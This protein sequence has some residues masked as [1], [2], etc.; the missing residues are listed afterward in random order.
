MKR[1]LKPLPGL[2]LVLIRALLLWVL[3]PFGFIFYLLTLPWVLRRSS[4]LGQFLG[5]LD[6]NMCIAI[7][8]G[9]LRPFVPKPLPAWISSR[10]MKGVTHRI[11][12]PIDLW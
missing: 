3:I 9:P 1:E 6:L 7:E 10:E 2:T 5:W 4:S 11:Q 8:R 12:L